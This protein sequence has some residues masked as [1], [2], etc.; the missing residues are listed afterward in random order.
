VLL[1]PKKK[2]SSSLRSNPTLAAKA[3]SKILSSRVSGT[4]FTG[5][6]MPAGSLK[7]CFARFSK[8]P[9]L[10]PAPTKTTPAFYLS[11]VILHQ[12]N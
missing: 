9:I 6:P 12:Q 11:V 4:I 2:S 7:T 8:P 10:E 5:I 1:C 3:G